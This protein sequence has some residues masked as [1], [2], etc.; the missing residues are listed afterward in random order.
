[1]KNQNIELH[2]KRGIEVYPNGDTGSGSIRIAACHAGLDFCGI[3]IDRE[4]FARMEERFSARCL[5]TERVGN[6]TVEHGN[7]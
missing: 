3:E 1:M 5:L 6:H 4:I 7:E 2:T